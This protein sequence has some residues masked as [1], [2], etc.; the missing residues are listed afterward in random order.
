MRL[1]SCP[2]RV[3]VPALNQAPNAHYL[4]VPAGKVDVEAPNNLFPKPHLQRKTAMILPASTLIGSG[5]SRTSPLPEDRLL[6]RWHPPR[7]LEVGLHSHQASHHC[8]VANV[9]EVKSG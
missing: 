5:L 1:H 2:R 3:Q 4:L 9:V 7:A 8:P 6:P